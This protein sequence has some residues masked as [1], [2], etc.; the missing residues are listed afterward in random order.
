M[1]IFYFTHSFCT[2]CISP[3]GGFFFFEQGVRDQ[4]PFI[5]L[6]TCLLSLELSPL[7]DNV[8]EK[9]EYC[10][11]LGLMSPTWKGYI[12]LLLTFKWETPVTWAYPAARGWEKGAAVCP[13]EQSNGLLTANLFLLQPVNSHLIDSYLCLNSF[14]LKCCHLQGRVQT[15]TDTKYGNISLDKNKS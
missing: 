9:M 2:G 12:S 8:G 6:T 14:D 5:S 1:Y 11:G 10:T 13:Q 15:N 7:R 4:V 3:S